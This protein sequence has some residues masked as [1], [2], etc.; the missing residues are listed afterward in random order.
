[1]FKKHLKPRICMVIPI[2]PQHSETFLLN[3]FLYLRNNGVN[4][5]IICDTFNKHIKNAAMKSSLHA[6]KK[7]IHPNYP[8]SSK[9]LAF[10]VF[11]LV[12]FITFLQSPITAF[13]YLRRGLRNKG[14]ASLKYFYL[15]A[16][17][18]QLKPAIIHFEFGALAVGRMHL[19]NF[20]N[21]KIVVSFR[22]FDINYTGLEAP[23]YYNE[24]F[25]KATA[26]HFLGRN[27]KD[28][29]ISRG[30][31]PKK[32]HYLIPPAID[33]IFYKRSTPR[34]I[35]KTFTP[36]RAFRILS[37]GRLCWEKGYEFGLQAIQLLTKNNLSLEYRI[38][39]GGDFL[40]SAAFCRYQMNLENCVTLLGPKNS[41]QI[42]EQLE[43]ADIFLHASVSEGFCNAVIEAQ[44]MELP[45][46]CT[47]AGGLPDNI[48]NGKTGI[49]VERRN[50]G[51]LAQAMITLYN[52]TVINK[53]MGEES[54]KRVLLYFQIE[55]QIN[56]FA[57]LYQ[58]IN[59]SYH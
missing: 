36:K 33:T 53:S 37:V 16:K 31:D 19:K 50:P 38:I 26:F 52:E 35:P 49:V 48:Q 25:S 51:P 4:V 43:W 45:V 9:F 39:G 44:A 12:F 11:P 5:S 17:F 18:I 30:W 57:Q 20:L 8:N 15:D 32:K 21:C 1:M 3:K 59:V 34:N 23:R 56:K 27:L 54:R 41:E 10:L 46:V 29:A 14:I 2:F 58:D 24:V 55:D 40:E 7:H 13:T 42:K 6:N 28:K 47:D 22:G